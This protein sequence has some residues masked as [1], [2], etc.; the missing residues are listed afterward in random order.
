MSNPTLLPALAHQE[1]S[2]G[3]LVRA[4]GATHWYDGELHE[5][6]RQLQ[7]CQH[8]GEYDDPLPGQS[9]HAARELA[10]HPG[11]EVS[12]APEGPELE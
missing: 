3:L 9:N 2:V 12:R 6:T 10:R 4:V 11:Q 1:R 8:I 7:A 5:E